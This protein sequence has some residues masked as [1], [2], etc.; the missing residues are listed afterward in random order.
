MDLFDGDMPLWRY[1]HLF[2]NLAGHIFFFEENQ[3]LKPFRDVEGTCVKRV[4]E[5]F[6][7][8]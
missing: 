7:M 5:M 6:I 4:Q 3:V 1:R 2:P 8:S